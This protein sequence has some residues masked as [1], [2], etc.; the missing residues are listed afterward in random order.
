MTGA[1]R[2]SLPEDLA[3]ELIAEE[4]AVPILRTRSVGEIVQVAIDIA[5]TGGSVVTVAAAAA[6]V[7]KVLRKVGKRAQEN[8]GASPARVVLQ[9]DG[10][11]IIVEVP[12]SLPLEDVASLLARS[13]ADVAGGATG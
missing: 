9:S 5:N 2:V 3:E 4:L 11:E 10:R 13:F 1:I 6:A 7:P 12:S 8:A